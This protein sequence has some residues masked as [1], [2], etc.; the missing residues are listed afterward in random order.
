MLLIMLKTKKKQKK[1]WDQDVQKSY[2]IPISTDWSV[3]S[4]LK[5]EIRQLE[6]SFGIKRDGSEC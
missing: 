1:K 3:T 6:K 5:M 2:F 4:G